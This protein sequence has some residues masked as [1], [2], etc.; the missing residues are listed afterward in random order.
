MTA[1]LG[2]SALSIAGCSS[3]SSALDLQ[4]PKNAFIAYVKLLG[5]LKDTTIYTSFE[6]TLS[7]VLPNQAPQVICR[8][9]G[10]ARS[11]WKTKPDG[12]FT[13]QSFDIGFFGDLETGEVVDEIVNPLTG[14]TVRPL[15]FKYGGGPAQDIN[16]EVLS[17]IRWSEIGG[18]IWLSEAGGGAFPHPMDM[19]KWPRESSGEKLF[20]RS[21]TDYVTTKRQLADNQVSSADQTLFWSSLLSWEPWLLMGQ[22]PGFTMW[23]GVGVKLK[24]SD[25]IPESMRAYIAKVQPNY[26]DAAPPWQQREGSFDRFMSLRK[27]S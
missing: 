22:T 16:K 13:K 8:Y 9:Q 26:L 20:Y 23:R 21:E 4:D 14:E 12:S 10:L 2:V 5:S 24:T 11:D 15:H 27:P 17:D 19:Q 18:N 25:Q 1:A 6:G 7:G 3:S